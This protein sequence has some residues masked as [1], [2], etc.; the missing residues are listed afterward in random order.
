MV[1]FPSDILQWC[2]TQLTHVYICPVYITIPTMFGDSITSHGSL[3]CFFLKEFSLAGM[4]PCFNCVP[5]LC[6]SLGL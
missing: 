4:K 3:T 2:S 5:Y 1:Y 6:Q